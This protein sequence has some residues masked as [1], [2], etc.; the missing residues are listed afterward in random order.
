MALRPS[1][2]NLVT[3]ENPTI[4]VKIHACVVGYNPTPPIVHTL[5]F[6]VSA[7]TVK[8]W[9]SVARPQDTLHSRHRITPLQELTDANLYSFLNRTT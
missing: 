2:S 3:V 9:S 1:P 8:I 4:L 5:Q 7:F 6:R